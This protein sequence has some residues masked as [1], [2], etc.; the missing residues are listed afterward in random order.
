MAWGPHVSATG[1]PSQHVDPVNRST[2]APGPPVSGPR[3]C[4]VGASSAPAGDA[5]GLTPATKTTAAPRRSWPEPCYGARFRACVGAFERSLDRA[6]SGGGGIAG[7]GRKRH[8]RRGPRRCVRALIRDCAK[9]HGRGAC[10]CALSRVFDAASIYGGGATRNGLGRRR[11]EA[12]RTPVFGRD[13]KR[14]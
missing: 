13:R 2:G 10:A 1:L 4:L 8:R 7:P 14:G 9:R 6:S 12:E 3:R 11:R 5:P